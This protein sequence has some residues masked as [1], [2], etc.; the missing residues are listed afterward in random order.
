MSPRSAVLCRVSAPDFQNACWVP[1][2]QIRSH[3]LPSLLLSFNQ[4]QVLRLPLSK[5][6]LNQ[7]LP[8]GLCSHSLSS[9]LTFLPG[10]IASQTPA[11][12][13]CHCLPH[14]PQCPILPPWLSFSE[15]HGLLLGGKTFSGSPSSLV[16]CKGF[17]VWPCFPGFVLC[18]PLSHS[19]V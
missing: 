11:C 5:Y 4:R 8:N 6:L 17:P 14:L 16:V 12:S 2:P 10:I 1:V 13:P 15:T 19:T 7:S 3:I 18:M 9:D